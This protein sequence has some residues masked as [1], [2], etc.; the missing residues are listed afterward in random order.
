MAKKVQYLCGDFEGYFYTNQK[1]TLSQSDQLPTD[2]AHKM[3]LYKGELK[4]IGIVSEFNPQNELSRDNVY[5]SNI[6]N[7]Q[8]HNSIN[9][10]VVFDKKIESFEYIV[11]DNVKIENSWELNDK[12]YGLL[13]A[14]LRGKLQTITSVDVPDDTEIFSPPPPI[15]PGNTTVKPVKPVPPA[16]TPGP[17]PIP[18]TPPAPPPGPGG[19]DEGCWKWF[20][21]I[22][23]WL[24]ILFFIIFLFKQCNYLNNWVSDNKCCDDRERLLIENNKLR[25][26][27]D[28]LKQNLIKQEKE[29]N[30]K[31][32]KERL[33]DEINR[34]SSK[35]YFNGGTTNIREISLPEINKIVR[36]LQ[37]YPGLNLEIQ[38]HYNGNTNT[39]GLDLQRANVVRDII[40]SKGV[41]PGRLTTIGLGNTN[42]VV[43]EN[44][45]STDIYGN[46]YNSNMRV[47]IKITKY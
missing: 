43:D 47:D 42:P 2:G 27:I 38:G 21:K 40:L 33:Q 37:Y 19:S 3:V 11:L 16:P 8:L 30:S 44:D 10:K 39:T 7:I 13:K 29:N 32:K 24:M 34:L 1:V 46:K 12:T 28:S 14:T 15:D 6:G 5:L 45:Y 41:D 26:T 31:R 23:L 20:W 22:L 18:P 17:I 4:N 36:L 9:K 25:T 35:I